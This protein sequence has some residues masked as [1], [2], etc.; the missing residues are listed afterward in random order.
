MDTDDI[1]AE[2]DSTTDRVNDRLSLL[3]TRMHHARRTAS[4]WATFAAV[5]AIICAV[6]AG[7]VML[8]LRKGVTRRRD[9]RVSDP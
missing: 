2:I 8:G 6:A 3:S 5:A 4:Q 1:R 7:V 9:R